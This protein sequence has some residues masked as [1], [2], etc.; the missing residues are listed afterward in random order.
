M[1]TRE[2]SKASTDGRR[3]GGGKQ[4]VSAGACDAGAGALPVGE[5]VGTE[6][7]A[8]FLLNSKGKQLG[9]IWSGFH[10]ATV[11]TAFDIGKWT[12]DSIR[13]ANRFGTSIGNY[14]QLVDCERLSMTLTNT[15]VVV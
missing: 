11:G 3:E 2:A 10:Q 5:A 8:R 14:T 13:E 9:V 4:D 6:T 15:S 12:A 1:T 7:V